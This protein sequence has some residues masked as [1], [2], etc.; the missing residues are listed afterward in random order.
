MGASVK[1]KTN[2]LF[3]IPIDKLIGMECLDGID[4]A[5]QTVGYKNERYDYEDAPI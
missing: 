2:G 1:A 3:V 5:L 4:I